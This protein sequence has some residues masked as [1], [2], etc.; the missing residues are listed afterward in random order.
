MWVRE[1]RLLSATGTTPAERAK[2]VRSWTEFFDQRIGRQTADIMR[3]QADYRPPGNRA[4]EARPR[5]A[6]ID[7]IPS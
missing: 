1:K 7:V 3:Q 6:P 2:N 4:V 5:A